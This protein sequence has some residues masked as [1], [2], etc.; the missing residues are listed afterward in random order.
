MTNTSGN[1]SLISVQQTPNPTALKYIL[2]AKHFAKP[3]SFP[4]AEAATDHPLAAQ[5][6]ALGA[7]YN[8]F[9]VQ[10]FVTVNKLPDVPWTPLQVQVQ[11]ILET[12]WQSSSV[13]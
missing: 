11:K 12:Y 6:F 7:I 8:V 9:M 4:S 2:P 3:L 13:E 1:E 5:L 10:D